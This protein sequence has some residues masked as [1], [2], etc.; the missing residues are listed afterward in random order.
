MDIIGDVSSKIFFDNHNVET[1]IKIPFKLVRKELILK[2]TLNI[3]ATNLGI[4]NSTEVVIPWSGGPAT[5][6]GNNN[7]VINRGETKDILIGPSFY[8]LNLKSVP[9]TIDG[10][11][12][13]IEQPMSDSQHTVSQLSDKMFEI[14]DDA[15]ALTERGVDVGFILYNYSGMKY[16]QYN[17]PNTTWEPWTLSSS[18]WINELGEN[19]TVYDFQD[20]KIR[21]CHDNDNAMGIIPLFKFHTGSRTIIERPQEITVPIGGNIM[22]ITLFDVDG[23]KRIP[24]SWKFSKTDSLL[25]FKIIPTSNTHVLYVRISDGIDI[26][27]S[28]HISNTYGKEDMDLWF[29]ACMYPWFLGSI[30][31]WIHETHRVTGSRV[32]G[33]RFV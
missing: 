31:L 8:D 22:D 5:V 15:R 28:I 11:I 3:S 32:H 6:L 29:H 30:D 27:K 14:L 16:L 20:L 23:D 18:T 9:E 24:I 17:H 4:I 25:S 19:N 2:G 33:S 26:E 10:L 7:T 12:V 13:V 1:V 21:H